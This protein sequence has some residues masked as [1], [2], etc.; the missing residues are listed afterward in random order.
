MSERSLPDGNERF[1]DRWSRRKRE[2]EEADVASTP[3]PDEGAARDEDLPSIDE[4]GAESDYSAF[5]REG[6][7]SDVRN[8]ALR[9]LWQSDPTRFAPDGLEEYGGD[10]T[11]S[12]VLGAAVKTVFKV[13]RGSNAPGQDGEKRGDPVD[14]EPEGPEETDETPGDAEA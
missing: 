3:E 10:H 4:L 12:P 9:A 7:P 13:A 1:L 2:A 8:R 5:M 14:G 6:V 11:T